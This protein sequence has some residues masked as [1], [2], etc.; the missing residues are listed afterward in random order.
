MQDVIDLEMKT[1]M[2]NK[3]HKISLTLDIFRNSNL[4]KLENEY[5]TITSGA[6]LRLNTTIFTS[7][8]HPTSHIEAIQ[9]LG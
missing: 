2:K 8:T 1:L 4:I 7:Y 3:V 6:Q 9:P 5:E